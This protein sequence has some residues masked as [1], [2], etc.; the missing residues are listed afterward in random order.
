MKKFRAAL[1]GVI[2]LLT[3]LSSPFANAQTTIR[4]NLST[5]FKNNLVNPY[6]IQMRTDVIRQQWCR[7]I[8]DG[9]H[10][11]WC[12]T[13]TEGG[14]EITYSEEYQA[15]CGNER[16]TVCRSA[17]GLSEEKCPPWVYRPGGC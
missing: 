10:A 4:S 1:V 14:I 8:N 17:T 16:V 3:G 5:V 6:I 13:P 11:E 2:L 7:I 12:P 15:L 9:E